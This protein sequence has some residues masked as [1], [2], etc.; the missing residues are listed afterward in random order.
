MKRKLMILPCLLL[1]VTV[2]IAI[3]QTDKDKLA[4][5]INTAD[6]A[7]TEKLKG[8][9][10]KRKSDVSIDGQVKLSTITEF[11]FDDQGKLQAKLVDAESSVKQKPGVRGRIQQSAAEDKADYVGKALELSLAYTYMTKGQLMDFFSKATIA[12]KDGVIEAT[13]ENIYVKG[14][15]LT[16]WVD[17]KTNLYTK[18]K[19]SSLLEKDAVDGEINYEKFSSGVNHGSTT[20]LNMPAQKMKIDAINQ[21]YSQRVK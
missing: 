17:K 21:D 13:G 1:M 11:S 15:K 20:V 10:W 9:I 16:I 5:A 6:E 8:Y 14:D 12:E 4:L 7:N 18:K 3:A 19:F 2:G